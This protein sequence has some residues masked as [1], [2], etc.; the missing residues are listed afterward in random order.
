MTL[1]TDLKK[2]EVPVNIFLTDGTILEGC[3]FAAEGQRLLDLMN[4]NR[5][6]IP[7]TDEDGSITI[8]QKLSISRIVPVVQNITD[9]MPDS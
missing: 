8:I 6:Y 2:D 4:D 7:Y 9:I 3:V 5:A 1:P